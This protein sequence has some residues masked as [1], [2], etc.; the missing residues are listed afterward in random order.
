ML[1]LPCADLG[2]RRVAF[3]VFEVP[4]ESL[5]DLRHGWAYLRHRG[6]VRL[7]GRSRV[8]DRALLRH[9]CDPGAWA[10]LDRAGSGW[11]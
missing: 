4:V 8:P 11:R 2:G 3:E 6:V 1:I 5:P 9:R 7:E 10:Q